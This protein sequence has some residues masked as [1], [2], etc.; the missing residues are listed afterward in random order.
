MESSCDI[1]SKYFVQ[2]SQ[3]K[4]DL[5]I[6]PHSRGVSKV[7]WDHR[8]PTLV[9]RTLD[10]CG[11]SDG[12]I[13]LRGRFAMWFCFYSSGIDSNR[14][15]QCINQQEVIGVV[16]FQIDSRP[17]NLA[18]STLLSR[19]S[20]PCSRGSIELVVFNTESYGRQPVLE[21]LRAGK[22]QKPTITPANIYLEPFLYR[23]YE[24]NVNYIFL[25]YSH[26]KASFRKYLIPP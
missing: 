4:P 26:Y 25:K 10:W 3:M 9:L 23:R 16:A 15:Y 11:S 17:V 19:T 12:P 22:R 13:S 24:E 7:I 6:K 5:I 20:G 8:S 18:N 21:N 2:I 1:V 14:S